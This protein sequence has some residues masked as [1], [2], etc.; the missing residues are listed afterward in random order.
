MVGR[1]VLSAAKA[2]GLMVMQIQALEGETIEGAER[3]ENYGLAGNPPGGAEGVMVEAGGDR[4]HVLIVA[5]EHRGFRPAVAGGEVKVYS[6]FEQFIH[7]DQNGDLII[8][9]PQGVKIKAKSLDAQLSEGITMQGQSLAITAPDGSTVN[10]NLSSSGQV[11]D[12][13]STM[14]AMRDIYNPHTH[15]GPTPD[16]AM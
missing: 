3:I 15:G 14:Q 8:S 16:N 2:S 13:R 6:Q 1:C 4:D 12:G 5:M 9:A 7:L 10:G 11:S